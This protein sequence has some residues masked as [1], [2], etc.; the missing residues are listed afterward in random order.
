MCQGSIFQH[1]S[2]NFVLTK[3][4]TSDR[5]KL[6]SIYVSSLPLYHIAKAELEGQLHHV[7]CSGIMETY[8]ALSG[9]RLKQ[10]TPANN[11]KM[12]NIKQ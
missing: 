4:A 10:Q 8:I 9:I 1:F 6:V 2:N 7:L 3:L 12:R 5:V 11:G